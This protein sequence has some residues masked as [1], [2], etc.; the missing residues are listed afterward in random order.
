MRMLEP[1][2][3]ISKKGIAVRE[4]MEPISSIQ[5]AI[6][7]ANNSRLTPSES[8]KKKKSLNESRRQTF[9]SSDDDGGDEDDENFVE[10]KPR[11]SLAEVVTTASSRRIP[12]PVACKFKRKS[13]E[14][15]SSQSLP[16]SPLTNSSRK[17]SRKSKVIYPSF[18]PAF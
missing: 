2:E 12:P 6:T 10:S 8:R 9:S 7:P 13:N 5:E 4:K 1:G 11:L 3:Q 17:Y 16:S 14:I 15:S 18:F